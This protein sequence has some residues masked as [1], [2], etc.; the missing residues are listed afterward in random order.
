MPSHFLLEILLEDLPARVVAPALEQILSRTR[1]ALKS[2]RLR[3]E[4]I[5]A[6]GTYRRLTLLVEGVAEKQEEFVEEVTGPPAKAAF[7]KDGKPTKVGIKFAEGKGGSPSALKKVTTSKGE[8]AAVEVRRGGAAA[9]D[10]LAEIVPKVLASLEFPL[11]MRWGRGEHSFI[12]PVH[13]V[14]ALLEKN[15]VPLS[16]C[17]VASGRTTRGHRFLADDKEIEISS[18]GDYLETMRKSFV[19]PDAGARRKS[20][21]AALAGRAGE[22]RGALVPDASLLDT[23]TAQVEWPVVLRGSFDKKFLEL[24]KE[25]LVSSMREHQ[26]YFAMEKDG[27]LLPHFLTVA[28][29]DEGAGADVVRN[30][31]RVLRARLEDARFFYEADRKRPLESHLEELEAATFHEKLG[32]YRDKTGRLEALAPT[33]AGLAGRADRAETLGAAARLSKCDLATAMVGEFPSLQG[34]IGGVYAR[35]EGRPEE[36]WRAV[37]EHYKPLDV[38]ADVEETPESDMG[39]LLAL[40]DRMDTLAGF[41]GAGIV[42]SGTKDP[43]A[44]R[45]AGNAVVALMRL[46]AALSL[47]PVVE[48]ACQG[49][50][51]RGDDAKKR[52]GE[53]LLERFESLDYFGFVNYT[54]AVLGASWPDSRLFPNVSFADAYLRGRAL[55]EMRGSD[56]L[57][58][59]AISFKRVKNI[60]KDQ[61][62]GEVDEK[63][64][65]E[66]TEKKL[67]TGI[68][69]V[70]ENVAQWMDRRDY[71][72]AFQALA[73]MRVLVD[74][75]FDDVLVMEEDEALRR[76][77]VALLYELGDL[78]LRLA[79]ISELAVSVR[80]KAKG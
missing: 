65:Q 10:I 42:P 63:L 64:L 52:L 21:E 20:I 16:F 49:H 14:A 50:G 70:R 43:Y 45:R 24:P 9:A 26:K 57:K 40:A 71:L 36:M 22:A 5:E 59:L 4:G 68:S 3:F 46:D 74:K 69:K 78:F 7:G 33:I 79:D 48:A 1:D 15:V 60:L 58:A 76:N 18:A 28:E 13:A 77:R 2:A 25:V 29:V 12:R 32:S 62:R 6:F 51:I 11:T 34:I 19:E 37:Y 23:V 27:K 80:D 8:Y 31:E 72:K 75:F 30:H 35:E 47:H 61:E 44:L 41:F 55:A 73:S 67:Y 66:S 56:D 39:R 53:F 38:R 54:R 17:G